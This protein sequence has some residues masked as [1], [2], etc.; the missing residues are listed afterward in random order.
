M[1]M[2]LLSGVPLF[3]QMFPTSVFYFFILYINI[4]KYLKII[5]AVDNVNI[6]ERYFYINTF[7][8]FCL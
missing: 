2:S 8:Y 6:L 4:N 3:S 7:Y 5:I 1:G